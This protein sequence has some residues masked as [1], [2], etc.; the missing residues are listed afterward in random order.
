MIGESGFTAQMNSA[1]VCT[2]SLTILQVGALLDRD[3]G[4]GR[5]DLPIGEI[6]AEHGAHRGAA[7]VGGED[8][9]DV[10]ALLLEEALRH[11][12]RIRHAVGGDAVIADDDLLGLH[13]CRQRQGKRQRDECES[14]TPD[15]ASLPG[16]SCVDTQATTV[17]RRWQP[18]CV[19]K[20]RV[21]VRW[22][23]GGMDL[24]IRGR[25]ALLSGA[26]RGLGKACALALAREGVEVTIV[27]RKPD[28]LERAA[29]GDP[30]AGRGGHAGRR[31]HHDAGGPQGRARRLSGTRHPGEQ[32]RRPAARRLPPAGRAMTG[33]RRSTP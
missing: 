11:R 10:G 8:A 26:S 33:S 23:E 30:R 6:A 28:A 21:V 32:C 4:R 29:D 20:A 2:L 22:R 9:G 15:H 18:E 3:H 7:A 5:V 31:R 1:T 17:W 19:T 14:T 24:G 25:K 13:W 27:A 16:V 12:D